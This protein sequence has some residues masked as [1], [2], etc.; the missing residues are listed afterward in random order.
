MKTGYNLKGI[1]CT[2]LV[3]LSWVWSAWSLFSLSTN[4][5]TGHFGLHLVKSLKYIWKY[6]ARNSYGGKKVVSPVR[7]PLLKITASH[8]CAIIQCWVLVNF[9]WSVHQFLFMLSNKSDMTHFHIPFSF[10]GYLVGLAHASNSE[11]L[12]INNWVS[13]Y[14]YSQFSTLERRSRPQLLLTLPTWTFSSFLSY[15]HLKFDCLF[16]HSSNKMTC[17]L[18]FVTCWL[19]DDCL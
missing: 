13:Q 2:V 3:C 15:L 10:F 8:C 18:D 9:L 19:I 5:T 17:V 12:W 16:K 1:Y 11:V 6:I 14:I 4:Q 7:I